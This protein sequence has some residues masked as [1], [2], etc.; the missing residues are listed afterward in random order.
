MGKSHRL[1][2]TGKKKRER[3]ILGLI[4]SR[5]NYKAITAG[6]NPDFE[7]KLKGGNLKFGVE[8]TEFYYSESHARINNI[9]GY[10]VDII[11]K[12]GYR[13]KDDPKLLEV[14]DFTL[15][16]GDNRKAQEKI[17]GILSKLPHKDEYIS[18]I[19]ELIEKKSQ[20]F[21]DYVV[22]LNHVNL[23][24]YDSENRLTGIPYDSFHFYFFNS[25]IEKA[26]VNSDFRE[27]YLITEIGPFPSPKKIYIPL[28]MLFLV[29]EVY[30]LNYIVFNHYQKAINRL[31]EKEPQL[32][33]EYLKWRGAKVVLYKTEPDGYEIVYG[34][35]SIFAT[36]VNNKVTIRNY[37]D[38]NISNGYRLSNDPSINKFFDHTFS[39]HFTECCSEHIFSSELFFPLEKEK[40]R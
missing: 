40:I 39:K 7:I 27:I 33:A 28:K 23:I 34:N 26:L 13:H 19:A 8:I 35:S 1:I 14:G 4:Y 11:N 29:A 32:V 37:N 22:G 21:D 24:I 36:T 6:E 20:R 5:N 10:A 2:N 12:E 3:E 15:I 38:Y 31:S 9:P 17:K 16:P 25:R 18:K 30:R